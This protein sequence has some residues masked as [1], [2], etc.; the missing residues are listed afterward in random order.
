M[1]KKLL[2]L[3]LCA[4]MTTLLLGACGGGNADTASTSGTSAATTGTSESSEGDSTTA[5]TPAE[6][7]SSEEAITLKYGATS[8]AG[9]IHETFAN[10]FA[11]NLNEISGGLITVEVNMGGVL[12]NTM[13]HYSQMT[14]GDLDFF[15]A[16]LDTGS[17]LRNG[18]DLAVVLVPFLFN[19]ENH[20][21][22]FLES[23][24]FKG[25]I[26]EIESANGLRFMG[27]LSKQLPRALSTSKVPVHS[28]AD[29][30]NLKIRT[31][32]STA[33]TEIWKAWGANPVVISGGEMYSALQ[34]GLADGQDNDV[35]N[36]YSTALHEVQD[37]F[38]E[39]N[40]IYQSMF[41]WM[42]EM[43]WSELS[44]QQQ[45]WIEQAIEKT[46]GEM[47]ELIDSSYESAKQGL[48]DGGMEFIEDVD[49]DSFREATANAIGTLEG[50][51]F[52][53]GLYEEIR[54]MAD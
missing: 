25:M 13:S 27:E 53:E 54:S 34:S 8:P 45:E 11:Q 51:L 35:V 47:A 23:D 33:M 49:L 7:G 3:L 15:Q 1:K 6:T 36:S 38:M 28:V 14:Q 50:S 20:Y 41:L 2:S 30:A 37:Y 39:I 10:T 22:K 18:G 9:S 4:G 52:R 43:T 21:Y 32:E 42:S 48:I 44:P 12:G 29:V 24:L 40:Y 16:A 31:P 19:D 17:G 26:S 46:H 5:E